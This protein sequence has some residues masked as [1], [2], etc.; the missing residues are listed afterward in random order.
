MAAIAEHRSQYPVTPDMFPRPL[1][2][3]ILGFEYFIQV[4]PPLEWQTELLPL[5]QQDAR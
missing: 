3:E 2:E 4:L 5:E 1:V